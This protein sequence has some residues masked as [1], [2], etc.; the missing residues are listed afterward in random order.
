MSDRDIDKIFAHLD[1]I[2]A[3][4]SDVKSS[5]EVIKT[6]LDM[7]DSRGCQKSNDAI[8]ELKSKVNKL[9]GIVSI[10]TL[11]F[12]GILAKIGLK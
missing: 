3:S 5:V 7:I 9:T 2:N 8:D 12:S 10:V 1:A 11:I 4:M 6:K